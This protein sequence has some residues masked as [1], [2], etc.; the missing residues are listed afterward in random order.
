MRIY[1]Y[2]YSSKVNAQF[3]YVKLFAAR[4]KQ[5]AMHAV[6]SIVS[7]LPYNTADVMRQNKC[8]ARAYDHIYDCVLFINL[9]CMNKWSAT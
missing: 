5:C 7:I 1:I 9:N 8:I 3:G 6:R 2:I 4:M